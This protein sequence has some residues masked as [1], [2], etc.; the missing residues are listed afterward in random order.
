MLF[1]EHVLGYLSILIYVFQVVSLFTFISQDPV[2]DVFL[3]KR[4][5]DAGCP[6]HIDLIAPTGFGEQHK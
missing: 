5:T 1:I 6:I 2:S 3:P 4:A